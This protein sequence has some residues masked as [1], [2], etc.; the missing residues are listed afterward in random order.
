MLLRGYILVTQAKNKYPGIIAGE[1]EATGNK[2]TKFKRRSS[3]RFTRIKFGG[4]RTYKKKVL[5]LKP[6]DAWEAAAINLEEAR[7]CIT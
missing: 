2:V 5:T 3:F 1:I 4:C 6:G 7:F